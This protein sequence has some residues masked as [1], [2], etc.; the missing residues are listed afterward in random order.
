MIFV[1]V[2]EPMLYYPAYI[3]ASW[4]LV[5]HSI[6]CWHLALFLKCRDFTCFE[7]CLKTLL[8]KL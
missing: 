3:H 6:W 8:I 2:P 5:R 4:Q 7:N 1:H